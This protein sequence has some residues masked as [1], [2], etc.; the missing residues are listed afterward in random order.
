MS[1]VTK[2]PKKIKIPPLKRKPVGHAET[3]KDLL[4]RL[5]AEKLKRKEK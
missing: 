5:K 1:G 3:T 2:K 4:A